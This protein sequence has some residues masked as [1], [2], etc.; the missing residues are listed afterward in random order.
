[1]VSDRIWYLGAGGKVVGPMTI[2]RVHERLATGVPR[3]T[4]AWREGM[5]DWA[6]LGELDELRPDSATAEAAIGAAP[7]G[8][9]LADAAAGSEGADGVRGADAGPIDGGD[10]RRGADGDG[11]GPSADAA[12]RGRTVKRGR[13]GTRP[14]LPA[15]GPSGVVRAARPDRPP[16]AA[17]LQALLAEPLPLAYVPPR[18]IDKADP[19]RAFALGHDRSR[20]A[21]GALAVL[22]SVV[23]FGGLLGATALSYQSREQL[24]GRPA[25]G[26]R[27]SFG[28]AVRH[29]RASIALPLGLAAAAAAPLAALVILSLF[30]KIPYVGPIAGGLAYGVQ[31][32]LG[33]A[34][35]VLL[36]ASALAGT[37]GP[38]VVAFEET[39]AR[40]TV[41][42]L[43]DLARRS[44]ARVAAWGLAPGLALHAYALGVSALAALSV[45]IPLAVNRLVIGSEGLAP[46]PDEVGGLGIG[47]VPIALWI[48][49]VL[50]A[51]A[52]VLASVT[53]AL[54]SILYLAGRA[55]NDGLPAREAAPAPLEPEAA[56]AS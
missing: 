30:M 2:E 3:R 20:I 50:V 42:L 28:F 16:L 46:G 13:S 27:E 54:V 25:P 1:L 55:G 26:L 4:K 19:W 9:A 17:R 34:A 41:Q 33:A 56:P 23:P 48:A 49:L 5:D 24:G 35:L 43:L 11:G 15:R 45:A 53:N 36:V 21:V 31:I 40:G 52:G 29:A 51:A 44:A 12:R 7:A 47:L 38:V 8:E 22:A 10:A 39:S 14:A 18:R 32:A 6:P 37:F